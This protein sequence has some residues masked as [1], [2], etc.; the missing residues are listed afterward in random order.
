MP[1]YC[2]PPDVFYKCSFNELEVLYEESKKYNHFADIPERSPLKPYME[3]FLEVSIYKSIS[4]FYLLLTRR[5][6]D[7]RP[8][9][10]PDEIDE[11]LIKIA[12]EEELKE[13]RKKIREEYFEAQEDI[14]DDI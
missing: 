7:M 4:Q 8:K 3:Q 5:Y 2:N 9:Y 10:T 14:G 6:I 13:K 1:K 12:M 11:C